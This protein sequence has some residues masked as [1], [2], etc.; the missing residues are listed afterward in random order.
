MKGL[1]TAIPLVSHH[2]GSGSIVA[3]FLLCCD[4]ILLSYSKTNKQKSEINEHDYK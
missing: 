3:A 2:K 1:V 4:C